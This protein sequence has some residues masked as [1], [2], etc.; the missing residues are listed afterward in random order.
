MFETQ[1]ILQRIA[2]D[3]GRSVVGL[4]RGARGGSGFVISP[5]R[6]VT[7]AR[8]L[9]SDQ[10][11]V[12]FAGGREAPASI[13]GTDGD[14]DLAVLAVDTADAPPIELSGDGAPAIGTAVVALANPGGR[15][16]RVTGGHVSI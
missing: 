8:N 2:S 15:G 5:G 6:V 13:A 14:V 9:R 3:V 4:Q 7:L 10:V 12:L 16:L 11:S 1:E